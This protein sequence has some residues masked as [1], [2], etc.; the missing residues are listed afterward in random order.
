MGIWDIYDGNIC[1]QPSCMAGTL[2]NLT[3]QICETNGTMLGMVGKKL[4]NLQVKD[5]SFFCNTS[6]QIPIVYVMWATSRYRNATL[7]LPTETMIT[8]TP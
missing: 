5:H 6:K 2:H 4:T 3:P 7:F 1:I 8:T